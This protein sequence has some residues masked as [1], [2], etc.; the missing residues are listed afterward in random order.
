MLNLSC[1][2][3]FSSIPLTNIEVLYEKNALIDKPLDKKPWEYITCPSNIEKYDQYKDINR[4]LCKQQQGWEKSNSLSDIKLNRPSVSNVNVVWVKGAFY[5]HDNPERYTGV[6]L[7]FIKGRDIVYIN[8]RLVGIKKYAINHDFNRHSYYKVP[9]GTLVKGENAVMMRLE[10][11]SHINGGVSPYLF[12]QSASDDEASYSWDNIFM[13]WPFFVAFVVIGILFLYSTIHAF[14]DEHKQVYIV[15]SLFSLFYI[16]LVVFVHI[17]FQ[18]ISVTLFTFILPITPYIFMVFIIFFFQMFYEARLSWENK[19]LV[20]LVIIMPILQ[21]FIIGKLSISLMIILPYV[22]WLYCLSTLCFV[23]YR[24]NRL[25]PDT[26]KL[27]IFSCLIVIFM[28]ALLSAI[29]SHMIVTSWLPNNPFHNI[30]LLYVIFF[31]VYAVVFEVREKKKSRKQLEELYQKFLKQKGSKRNSTTINDSSEDKMTQ[32]IEFI[33]ENY[34]SNLPRDVLA[35]TVKINPSYLSS[36]FN[37]YTGKKIQE[38]INMLRV[39]EAAKLI[40]ETDKNIID[41]AFSVGFENLSTFIKVF[42]KEMGRTPRD[43]RAENKT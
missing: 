16:L 12:L 3:S 10:I 20:P 41:I 21:H 22:T 42:K 43:L 4:C 30:F 5:I 23:L 14:I 2:T 38:Y 24:L 19:V 39:K 34:T 37:S 35:A 1:N 9:P 28:L 27:C 18:I 25:K 17:P 32:V 8:N 11:I 7:E 40:K 26:V 15:S 13:R 6:Y 29:L 33:N 36:L 31:S